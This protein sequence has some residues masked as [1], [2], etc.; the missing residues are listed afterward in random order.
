MPNDAGTKIN[1]HTM[2]KDYDLVSVLY[3]SLQGAEACAKYEQDASSEGSKEVAEFMHE[4]QEQQQR[5]A[6]K[7]KELLFKQKQV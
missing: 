6:Q 2:D 4:V 7:A 5:I 3:H 1:P